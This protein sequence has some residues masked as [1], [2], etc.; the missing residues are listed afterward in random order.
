MIPAAFGPFLEQ[1]PLCVMTRAALESLFQPE[2]LD[3]LFRRTAQK[4]YQKELLFSRVVELMTSVVLRVNESVHDAYRKRADWLPVSDQAVYD[5]AN[6]V[7][8]RPSR[9]RW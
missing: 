5:R 2:Q 6:A 4:Q 1:T 3:A 7:W 8:S 9:P